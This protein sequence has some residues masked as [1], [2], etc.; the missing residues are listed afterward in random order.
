MD[1]EAEA[2]QPLKK[3]SKGK[4]FRNIWLV[5]IL[6]F[7]VSIVLL[8]VDESQAKPGGTLLSLGTALESASVLIG[9]ISF[10]IWVFN[11]ISNKIVKVLFV[12]IAS[13][14]FLVIPVQ[15]FVV[16]WAAIDGSSMEPNFKNGEYYLLNVFKYKFGTPA[17]KDVVKY[18]LNDSARVGR[19]IGL[20]NETLTIKQGEIKING[21]VLNESYAD[22]SSWPENDKKEVTL[23]S[24]EYLILLDKRTGS[25]SVVNKQGIV[26]KFT[27]RY[28]PSNRAGFI[29][30]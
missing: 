20:P 17:R 6:A 9:G 25:V 14:I 30:S 2:E 4:V 19:V 11:L 22:W 23:H 13:I 27:Y 29:S 18:V 16:Q 1:K 12:L 10:I 15:L 3:S 26:G 28:W 24:N 8:I 7:I 21:K 5:S